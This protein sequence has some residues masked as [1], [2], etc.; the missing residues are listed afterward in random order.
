MTDSKPRK[1]LTLKKSAA[2]TPAARDI[3]DAAARKRSGA[4]ARSAAQLQ[5]EREKAAAIE[6]LAPA[7]EAP[8]KPAGA[9]SR[10]RPDS[11]TPRK[12]ARRFHSSAK[13]RRTEVFQVFAPCPLGL[14]AVL[15]AELD[16]L[17]YQNLR[18]ARAG[19][20]FEADW[21]GVLRANLYSRLATRILVRVAH[22]PVRT[23]RKSTRLNSS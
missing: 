12:A 6:A 15:H 8:R 21:T 23:D 18:Q 5:R 17:G 13:T 20:H 3:H 10:R 22:A 11:G 16:A 1:T 2:P 9:T 14:E 7:P 19:C 4:R